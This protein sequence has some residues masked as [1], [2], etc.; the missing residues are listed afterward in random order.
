MDAV[1]VVFSVLTHTDFHHFYR[2]FQA[3]ETLKNTPETP[4]TQTENTKNTISLV[5]LG[6]VPPV[7]CVRE[8]TPLV[9]LVHLLLRDLLAQAHQ[10]APQLASLVNP[11]AS[12]SKTTEKASTNSSFWSCSVV[13]GPP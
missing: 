2:K 11:L 5:G 6:N 13:C 1:D 4:E 10:D 3:S 8:G 9:S 7:L 12:T